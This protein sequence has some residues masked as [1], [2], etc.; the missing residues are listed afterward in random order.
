MAAAERDQDVSRA[1]SEHAVGAELFAQVV[2]H[3]RF[4][5]GVRLVGRYALGV[6]VPGAVVGVVP[7]PV[8]PSPPHTVTPSA[9]STCPPPLSQPERMIHHEAATKF[10]GERVILVHQARDRASLGSWSASTYSCG[11]GKERCRGV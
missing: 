1:R 2:G 7:Q 8:T 3:R 6:G 9:P 4:I 5:G 10:H 11:E